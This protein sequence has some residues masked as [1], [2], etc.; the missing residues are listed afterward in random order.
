MSTIVRL[1]VT[2][3][4]AL[5]VIAVP[6]L[7]DAA[8]RPMSVTQT[9]VP[10]A[11]AA[12]EDDGAWVTAPLEAEPTVVGLTW[13]DPADVPTAAEIRVRVD[14][15]WGRWEVLVV[16]DEHG[17]DP[18][19]PE[20]A[21]ARGGTSPVVVEGA[22]A[23]QFRLEGPDAPGRVTAELI[24]VD[25]P[26][27]ARR[28]EGRPGAA[29]AAPPQPAMNSRADWDADSCVVR[30]PE[31]I[32][33]GTRTQ[34]L[35]V[36]HTAA[37]TNHTREAVPGIIQGICRYHVNSRGWDDIG[38]NALIDR[39]GGI[40]AGRAGGLAR[41]PIGAHTGGFNSMSSGVAF[42]G[43]HESGGAPTTAAQDALRRFAAW[44]LDVHNIDPRARVTVES[45]GS[46]RHPE[47]RLVEMDAISGHRDASYTACPGRSC[48][49]LLDDFMLAVD[50]TPGM[51]IF[52]GWPRVDRAEYVDG[53]W[54]PTEV[55]LEF[56]ERADW[57][58][59]I[60]DDA[61]NTVLRRT[62]RDG[63]TTVRWDGTVGGTP[64]PAGT[65]TVS[66][67]ARSVATGEAASPSDHVL[68]LG[69]PL[70]S[71]YDVPL[72][73]VFTE[74][75]RWLAL[76]GI[77]KGCNPPANTLFCPDA[78]VKRGQMAAFINRWLDLPPADHAGFRDVPRDHL[79]ADDVARLYAAGITR[80]CSTE[81]LR[82]CPD[83]P[84]SRRQ[85]AAFIVRATGLRAID[86]PGFEDVPASSPFRDDIRRLATAG[87]TRGCNPPENTRYCPSSD[88][89]RGQMA[90]F[91][92]RASTEG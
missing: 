63:T 13:D 19:T 66:T 74:D 85:M 38:Y 1:F 24:D 28:V 73:S 29:D 84:V 83:E 75:I 26:D 8:I 30:D 61:G 46:S 23:V 64:A 72:G 79:F 48:Y 17:P 91:V 86:H 10:L 92:R 78:P 59:E 57:T 60:R 81:P 32:D 11:F 21:Q 18:G 9:S 68:E 47:G 6:L 15:E 56:S 65:Y 49:S 88:V 62:G 76:A 31:D 90:A 39:H 52:G 5:A 51:R 33:Y 20:A 89:T 2:L 27:G 22:Q 82:F 35:F 34:L 55:D 14:G 53:S 36:H 67:T 12:A 71:F 58:L 42:I 69:L 40:W 45:L 3:G 41:N 54:T 43:D 7:P 4:V 80:G 37:N 16:D 77:T 44:K 50:A 25:D 87:V 70:G